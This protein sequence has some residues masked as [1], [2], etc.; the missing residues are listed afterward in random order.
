VE[1]AWQVADVDTA[2]VFDAEWSLAYAN[3]TQT[4]PTSGYVSI[5]VADV[6][7]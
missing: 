2:G 5:L 7:A 6:L 1:Y 3:G 4:V